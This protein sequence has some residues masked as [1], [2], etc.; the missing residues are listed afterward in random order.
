MSDIKWWQRGVVYQIYPR[1]FKDSNH[2]GVGDLE[3]IIEKIDYLAELG[4]D[5][6][7][8]SPFYPSPMK[9]F[10]YD[11]ADY[12]DIDPLF[13]NL[14]TFDKLVNE[15]HAR[16]MRVII[17]WVPNHT[18]DQHP[19]FKESRSSRNNPKRDWYIW[20][21]AKP[22]GSLPNNWGSH[23]GG[24]VWEWDE[25]TQQYYF[26]QFVKEQPD[27]NWRNPEV[28][29]AMMDV[30]RFWMSRGVD[31][32]RMDV[33]YM[34]S[35]HPDLPDHPLLLN[36]T[37]RNE[38]DI[39]NTQE[40][41]Y[42]QDYDGIHDLMRMIRATLDEFGDTVAVG[43]IWLSLDR[44]KDYYGTLEKPELHLPF[45]FRLIQAEWTAESLRKEIELIESVVPV[46]GFPNYV[47]NNHD[48]RRFASRVGE[49]QAKNAGMLL[50]TLRGTP[51]LYQGEELGMLDGI[52]QAHQMQDPQGINLGVAYTRDVCRT[53]FLWDSSDTYAGFST[54]TPWL[55]INHDY[56]AYAV[57]TLSKDKHSILE[58]YRALLNL[59]RSTN[60]LTIG[61]YESVQSPKGVFA[62]L[63]T[64]QSERY[65][66]VLNITSKPI[67][68][69]HPEKGTIVLDTGLKRQGEPFPQVAELWGD[70]GIIIKLA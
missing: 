27:L 45:N 42:D 58:L 46:H 66:I 50:L 52:I 61:R 43:E 10:G 64:Y 65:L 40:H 6:L 49:K 7:W 24:S 67:S 19:W 22:D 12:C 55:P 35:K 16:Q 36:A 39:Y 47:L 17:D 32:F 2:D 13:G 62:Y 37:I 53:P 8:I 26:H 29:Q 3:G 57:D 9:D 44:W 30:L 48:M 59:R 33:V 69:E 38:N 18:S 51:T 63:R 60:A 4:V 41:L 21:D 56:Q 5:I 20:R 25:T 1:S 28:Q 23:F 15:A 14:D 11:V 70:E 54:V 68:F 34:I 31:G